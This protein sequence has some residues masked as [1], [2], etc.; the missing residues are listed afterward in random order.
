MIA[1]LGPLQQALVEAGLAEMPKPRKQ[2]NKNFKCHRCGSPMEKISDT[3]T[4]AC[5]NCNNY[6]IFNK[7]VG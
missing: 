7:T 5:T 3:N 2:Q 1:G 4:M 6:F